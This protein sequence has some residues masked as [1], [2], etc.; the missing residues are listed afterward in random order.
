MVWPGWQMK[1]RTGFAA[2]LSGEGEPLF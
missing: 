1:A 2:L